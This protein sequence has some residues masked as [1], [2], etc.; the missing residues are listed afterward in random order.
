MFFRNRVVS[1]TPSSLVNIAAWAAGETHGSSSSA[2]NS[3]Q[4]PLDR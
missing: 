4:V 3:D 2:P 1:R